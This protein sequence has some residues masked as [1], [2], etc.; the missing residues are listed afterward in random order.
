MEHGITEG[1]V[2]RGVVCGGWEGSNPR[3]DVQNKEHIVNSSHRNKMHVNATEEHSHQDTENTLRNYQ[4]RLK[5]VLHMWLCRR[6][7]VMLEG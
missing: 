1:A 2:R 7:P 5:T 4:G 3:E 6:S